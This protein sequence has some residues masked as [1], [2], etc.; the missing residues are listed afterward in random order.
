MILLVDEPADLPQFD[1]TT[2]HIQRLLRYTDSTFS[3]IIKRR[4]RVSVP[5][6]L[7]IYR[8]RR[9]R[10]LARCAKVWKYQDPDNAGAFSALAAL[11]TPWLNWPRGSISPTPYQAWQIWCLQMFSE[12]TAGLDY[13]YLLDSITQHWQIVWGPRLTWGTPTFDFS[14]PPFTVTNTHEPESPVFFKFASFYLVQPREQTTTRRTPQPRFLEWHSDAFAYYN[15]QTTSIYTIPTAQHS[16]P[17]PLPHTPTK[18]LVRF[19]NGQ[20]RTP[21]YTRYFLGPSGDQ[22][23]PFTHP[24]PA[25]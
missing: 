21:D 16:Y 13:P 4:P 12:F 25:G 8:N 15:D 9:N 6:P 5:S 10:F 14:S 24:S 19:N 7:S 2:T 17:F 3:P 23:F 20:A 11:L 22:I 18:A 1:K